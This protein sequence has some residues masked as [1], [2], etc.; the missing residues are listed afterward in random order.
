MKTSVIIDYLP[1]S[2]WRYKEG[3]AVVAVDVIRATT[4]AV[5]AAAT[6]RR[7]Y[8]APTVEAAL[9]LAQRFENPLLAG[10]TSGEVSAG[11]E[12]D[13]SPSQLVGRTDVHRPLVL[14]SSSGTRVIHE[15][16][17]C[18]ATY[19]GCFRSHSVLPG[20]LA[21]RHARIAVIGAGS[22]GEFREEDQ[23]CCAWI[24]AGLL[25]KGY[26]PESTETV[27]IVNRWRSAP[28]NACLCSNSVSFLKR[29]GRHSDLEFILN[30]V[31]DL[32]AVFSVE[33][34]EVKMIPG[35]HAAELRP[36]ANPGWPSARN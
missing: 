7:C 22:K 24:A 17:G 3:W 29:T 21:G 23:I 6:G 30:H 12:M 19:L 31:D 18:E 28:A 1:E 4:T 11:F 15:A 16:A 33:D 34:G 25:S 35:E 10:E 27:D 8:P 13:N 32:R 26:S 2:V 5:T 14:V 9:D 20:Y 36:P